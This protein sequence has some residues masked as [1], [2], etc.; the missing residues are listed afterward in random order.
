MEKTL[1][2]KAKSI[3]TFFIHTSHIKKNEIYY[4]I[5]IKNQLLESCTIIAYIDA[6]ARCIRSVG[7]RNSIPGVGCGPV[8]KIRIEIIAKRYLD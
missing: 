2:K 5:G 1:K 3:L 7:F 8:S 4:R 6:G